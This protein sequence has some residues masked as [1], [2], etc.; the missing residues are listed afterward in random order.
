MEVEPRSTRDMPIDGNRT[1]NGRSVDTRRRAF[2][3][4][5]ANGVLWSIGNG[6]TSGSLITYLAID[7][8]AEG[9]GVSMVLAI[10]SMV[11]A[12]RILSPTTVAMA[13]SARRAC[14]ALTLASYALIMLLP[15]TTLTGSPLRMLP[16]VTTLVVLLC[17]HQLLEQF[18]TVAMWT[19]WS[20]LVPL[21]IRGRYFGRR[22]TLQLAAL[23]PTV[24]ASGWF[25]DMWKR[26]HPDW[27]L[28]GYAM[29]TAVGAAF[30]LA[31]IVPLWFMP[32]RIGNGRRERAQPRLTDWRQLLA[33]LTATTFRRVLWFG[34][35][36]SFVN[37]LTQSAQNIYPKQVLAIGLTEQAA[38]VTIMRLGQAMYSLWAGPFSDRYGNRPVLIVS[39]LVQASGLLFFVL[40]APGDS[41]W[42]WGAW[43]A[44]SAFAG[45]N[46]CVPNLL[47]KLAPLGQTAAYV[48][49]YTG[50][51]GAVYAAGTMSGGYLHDWLKLRYAIASDAAASAEFYHQ[52]FLC[53]WVLRSMAVL[54]LVRVIEPG[55][56]RWREIVSKFSRK[57]SS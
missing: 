7:L 46:I 14:L 52:L 15:V 36:F 27:K 51:T 18:G 9:V 42:L 44:W 54:W 56:W 19:W 37:G 50:L 8:G 32:E 28:A 30:L 24:W 47:L 43:I 16:P 13:G 22:N 6:L 33:P 23:I 20:N 5:Y 48:G 34:L 21:P 49:I 11:G 39:Q 25:V 4:G 45:I 10:Q 29:V 31:S 2:R 53:G 40:A 17:V 12:L 55:A 41:G 26:A 57:G 35:M 3:L 38:F 1:V